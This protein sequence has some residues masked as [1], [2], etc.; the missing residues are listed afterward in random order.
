MPLVILVDEHDNA[1]GEMDK[2]AAH[3]QGRC[4]RAFSVFILRH[5]DQP[6][7]LLQQRAAEKYH[8]ANLWT[9]TC[10]S[11]PQPNHQ[12]SEDAKQRLKFEMGI[13][14]T[15]Q[16]ASAF[17]Y[18]AVFDNGLTENEVDHVF[19]AFVD[20]DLSFTINPQEAQDSMW[21]SIDQLIQDI[22]RQPHRY[23]PWLKPAL[24]CL[25]Q[26]LNGR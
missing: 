11:H 1:I 6:E 3:E 18:V 9:N 26:A 22:D 10:C 23:T 12:L 25:H 17:H 20:P 15:L 24:T 21:V 16:Y 2:L 19:Y 7:V 5:P 14:Q 13:D 8:C 4:H